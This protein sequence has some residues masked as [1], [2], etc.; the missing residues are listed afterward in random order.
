M[1]PGIMNL[2]SITV[3]MTTGTTG[4]STGI[5]IMTTGI[6]IPGDIAPAQLL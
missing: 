5:L 6:T 1:I 4:M 2:S 3:I